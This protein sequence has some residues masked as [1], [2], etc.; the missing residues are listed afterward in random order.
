MEFWNRAMGNA[1]AE[2]GVRSLLLSSSATRTRDDQYESSEIYKGIY[3]NE[4]RWR[5][6]GIFIKATFAGLRKAKKR[7]ARI[8]HFHIFHIGI[9]QYYSV[10][11]SKI[12]GFKVLVSAHDVG[13]FRQGE[14]RILLRAFYRL[15]D[16]VLVYSKRARS[17]LKVIVPNYNREIYVSVHGNYIGLFSDIPSPRISKEKFGF[18]EDDFVVLFFGQLK[19]VKR[20]DLLLRAIAEA[21]SRGSNR[22]R[23]LIAGK[24]ADSDFSEINEIINNK[25]LSEI[26]RI[27]TDY[28]PY[29]ELPVYLGATNLVALPYDQIYQ[30][31]VLLL[32]MSYEIPVLA[33][34]LPGM[35][36]VIE[37]EVTG[38]TFCAGD[39]NDLADKLLNAEVGKW[40]LVKIAKNAKLVA[41]SKHSWAECAKVTAVAYCDLTK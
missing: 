3:G 38:L 5:R 37:D 14:S 31:G 15:S 4:S 16:A 39:M 33:S 24:I 13:S 11:I 10:V 22:L 29:S 20:L 25:N 41:S 9:L 7:G 40:D 17:E 2:K 1:L 18:T 35:T 8:A 32:A 34:D 36:E 6:A 30:S 12:M 19:R 27:K 21:K 23:L 26:I 28:I